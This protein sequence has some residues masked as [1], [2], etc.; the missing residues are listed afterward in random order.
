MS[1]YFAEVE[2]ELCAATARAR[3]P[4]YR[5]RAPR[6]VASLTHVRL[7]V[8]APALVLATA[9]IALAA[10]GVILTGSPVHPVG[11]PNPTVGEG[12]PVAGG[13]R[14]LALRAPDPAGGL[15]WGIRVTRTTRGLLCVQV[16]R[17]D[18]GQ[19]GELGVDGAFGNDGRFHPLP[20]DALPDVLDRVGM[21]N[22]DCESPGL[23]FA[24]DI[25]GIQLSAAGNPRPGV[26]PAGIAGRSPSACWG[27]TR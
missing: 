17:V 23:I 15:P 2:R 24:G 12:V 25:V 3:L 9:T 26:G 21:L 16:G 10:T 7:A 1:D 13:S 5:R 20:S 18:H 19:I 22:S 11:R 4:W 8:A 6:H 14:V 27:R